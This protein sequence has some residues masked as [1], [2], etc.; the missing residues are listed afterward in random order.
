MREYLR[1]DI[2]FSSDAEL[3]EHLA[4]LSIP[5]ADVQRL[6]RLGEVTLS[7]GTRDEMTLELR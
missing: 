1:H 3:D 7:P 4:M 6:K 5:T 2:T